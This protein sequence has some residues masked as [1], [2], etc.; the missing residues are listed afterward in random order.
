VI[1]SFVLARMNIIA[2][3]VFQKVSLWGFGVVVLCF[4]YVGYE[5]HQIISQAKALSSSLFGSNS[6]MGLGGLFGPSASQ[7]SNSGLGTAAKQITDNMVSV[8]LWFYIEIISLIGIVVSVIK[9][10]KESRF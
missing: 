5:I 6:P 10:K 7:G 9:V 4:V 1:A 8:T 3:D 2:T